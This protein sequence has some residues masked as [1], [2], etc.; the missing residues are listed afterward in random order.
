MQGSNP[1]L[2]DKPHPGKLP[3]QRTPRRSPVLIRDASSPVT[4]GVLHRLS[5]A[6]VLS[7]M[8]FVAFAPV[9]MLRDLTFHCRPSFGCLG[10]VRG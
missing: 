9:K 1:L 5:V 10:D 3:Q 8:F 2:T 7:S 6:I 4:M